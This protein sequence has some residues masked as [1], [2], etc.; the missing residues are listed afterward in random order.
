MV[1]NAGF[2]QKDTDKRVSST[3]VTCSELGTQTFIFI[4]P[5]PRW[6]PF[7]GCNNVVRAFQNK[8]G[9]Q[10]KAMSELAKEYSTQ[11]LGL[12]LGGE[13]V[14]IVYGLKNIKQV[15]TGLEFEGRPDNFFMRLR[16]FGKRTGQ[17][18]RFYSYLVLSKTGKQ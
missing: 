6:Y 9:S 3:N 5:G 11:V 14:I 15:F 16:S 10:W 2:M 7:I 4:I 8:Y 12:K 13:L 17:K 1:V 18:L